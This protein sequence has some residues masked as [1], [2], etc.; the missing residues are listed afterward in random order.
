[1]GLK[2]RFEPELRSKIND[3][4]WEYSDNGEDAAK[5]QKEINDILQFIQQEIDNAKIEELEKLKGHL[6]RDES[7]TQK[8]CTTI[9]LGDAI[10]NRIKELNAPKENQ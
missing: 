5:V 8:H 6:F 3:L 10:Y 4:L 1:M 2:E 9:L 7:Y